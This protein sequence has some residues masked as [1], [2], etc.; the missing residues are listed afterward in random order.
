[1]NV[2]SRPADGT[3]RSSFLR[4]HPIASATIVAGSAD[5]A[6]AITLWALLGTPPVRVLQAIASGLIGPG[7]FTGGAGTAAL[8]A[9]L[10]YLIILAMAAAYA[11]VSR[12]SLWLN[13]HRLLGGAAYGALL[14]GLMNFIVVP[15]SLAPLGRPPLAIAI[16]DLCSHIL[17]VGIPIALLTSSRPLRLR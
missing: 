2:A 1:M 7:S 6:F 17:L 16:A 3:S 13:E 5:L 4:R 12:R 10:H 11:A 9:V 8:G 14:Y 15:L